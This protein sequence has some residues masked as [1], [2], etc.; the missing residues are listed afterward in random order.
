MSE[1][2]F[3]Y[4]KHVKKE[5]ETNSEKEESKKRHPLSRSVTFWNQL[6]KKVKIEIIIL[7]VVL[8]VIIILVFPGLFNSS[9][10]VEEL[11]APPAE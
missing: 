9:V 4:Q 3:H 6:D 10:P 7:I 8:I 2:F 11:P 5:K 1:E